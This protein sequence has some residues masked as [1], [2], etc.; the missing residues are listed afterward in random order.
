MMLTAMNIAASDRAFNF[1]DPAS[2]KIKTRAIGGWS[3]YVSENMKTGSVSVR[4]HTAFLNMW[5]EKFIFCGK[6]VGPTNNT[7][8]MAE[9]LA[10]GNPVPLGKHLLGSVYHLLHQVSAKL[11][12]DQPI[13]NL[14]GPWW[15]IQLW[16]N[17][18]MH[19][20][21]GI[22]LSELSF[23]SEEFD[24]EEDPI[25]RRCTSFGEAAIMIAN[26]SNV[27]S[28]TDFFKCFYNGFTED[29]TIW[30]AYHDDKREYENPFKFNLDSWKNDEE[31][32][33]IMR[34]AISP[35]ILP[36]NFTSGKSAIGYE[37]CYPSVVAR[38]LGF[39]QVPP[40]FYFA[41]KVQ[42]RNPIGTALTY[43]R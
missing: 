12:A 11:R 10:S 34:E 40:L 5:L 8:K 29:S 9:T 32:T 30:F 43:N 21:M 28:K 38:Q 37:F 16:L 23:P 19:K 15:F 27:F 6:T 4:E 33:N 24:E 3:G 36:A 14:R 26:D 35:R 2:F 7:L 1:L 41:D 17:M 39:I 42:A 13:S 18:Y 31:A 22:R 25:T 20:T